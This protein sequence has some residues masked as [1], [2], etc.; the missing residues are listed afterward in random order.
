MDD[1]PHVNVAVR[2]ALMVARVER[3]IFGH[4]QSEVGSCGAAD[5]VYIERNMAETVVLF[6]YTGT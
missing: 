4:H 5:C 2:E 3:D 6:L 1:P